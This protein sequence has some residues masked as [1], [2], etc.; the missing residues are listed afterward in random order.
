MQLYTF[1]NT[2]RWIYDCK[3][4]I[5]GLNIYLKHFL[6]SVTSLQAPLSSKQKRCL[7]E[8]LECSS[9]HC[10]KGNHW[11]AS[12]QLR[13]EINNYI[14]KKI[15]LICSFRFTLR[16]SILKFCSSAHISLKETYIAYSKVKEHLFQKSDE[17]LY[18]LQTQFFV[19]LQDILCEKSSKRCS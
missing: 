14:N 19:D 4:F 11:S 10:L 13:E 6:T 16:L 7:I 3:I 12:S 18:L 1:W 5:F 9:N 2:W 15:P 17:S 8:A